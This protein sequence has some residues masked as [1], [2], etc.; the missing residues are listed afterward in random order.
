MLYD[1]LNL[2][3]V[4]VL[5]SSENALNDLNIKL[6]KA[7]FD[8]TNKYFSNIASQNA[9]KWSA[10]QTKLSRECDKLK[11]EISER[12]VRSRHNANSNFSNETASKVTVI[13]HHENKTLSRH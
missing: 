1:V 8:E 9:K 10:L 6:N 4:F 7:L 13:I 3:V 5:G 11:Q 12:A 2:A